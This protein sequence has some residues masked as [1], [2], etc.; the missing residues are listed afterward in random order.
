MAITAATPDR[1]NDSEL[2]Y[3]DNKRQSM[4]DWRDIALSSHY[5]FSLFLLSLLF[6][7]LPGEVACKKLRLY[8]VENFPGRNFRA[9]RSIPRLT[10][11]GFLLIEILSP[12]LVP[13]LF[14]VPIEQFV[15]FFRAA[16]LRP[17]LY[18]RKQTPK[19]Y[20]GAENTSWGIGFELLREIQ[21]RAVRVLPVKY[22]S[23]RANSV[24]GSRCYTIRGFHVPAR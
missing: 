21:G 6:F 13:T 7:Y 4:R 12:P 19:I 5:F 1:S 11:P 10:L 2:F 14:N 9:S 17:A 22:F 16:N 8:G 15:I 23:P 20:R 24:L 18:W 3:A